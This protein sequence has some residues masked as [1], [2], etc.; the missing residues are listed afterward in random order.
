MMRWIG[1][2]NLLSRTIGPF[3]M[4]HA[5]FDLGSWILFL[6]T[7][8]LF[9]VTLIV[10]LVWFSALTPFKAEGLGNIDYGDTKPFVEEEDSHTESP[11]SNTN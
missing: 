3:W 7:G 9:V 2:S 8:I 1:I 11:P 5:Y 6:F 10:T 4:I